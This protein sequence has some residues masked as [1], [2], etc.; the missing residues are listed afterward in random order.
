MLKV[1]AEDI[2]RLMGIEVS[3]VYKMLGRKK[4]YLKNK[5]VDEIIDMIVKKRGKNALQG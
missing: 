1:T 3:S 5:Y 2:A 4:I